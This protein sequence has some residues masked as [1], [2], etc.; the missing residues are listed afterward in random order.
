MS[1]RVPP[2]ARIR[3]SRSLPRLL[4]LP[5]FGL[6][7]GAAMMAGGLL[8]VPGITGLV[9]AGLGATVSLMSLAGAVVLLSVRLE[10]EEAAVCLAW[11][12]GE[13]I[14]P[15][16]PGPVTRVRLRGETASRLRAAPTFLPW[17]LGAGRLRDEEDVE[18]VRLAPTAT[19]ILVPTERGRLAIAAADEDALLDA[20]SRAARAR[21]RLEELIRESS[22]DER[23]EASDGSSE[24]APEFMTG[25]ER[26]TFE[27]RLA[28]ELAEAAAA[29]A[30][31]TDALPSP[32]AAEREA[33]PP[34]VGVRRGRRLGLRRPA[35]ARRPA[36]SAGLLVLP[37]LGAGIVWGI[38]AAQDRMPQPATDL[39]R[40]TA[41]ALV[42]GGPATTVGAI[43]AR[44]WWPRL[45]AVVVAGGL[46]ATV[47]VGRALLG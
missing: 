15:L 42:L 2:I 24:V 9:V 6:L 43:M 19:A 29:A 28:A 27:R 14:Y 36:P 33:Q 37:L 31:R 20:L 13:R 47:F 32:E 34:H 40:L 12:G 35:W 4:A 1:N 41:L 7:L 22:P 17:Q 38:A 44:V 3:L 45:V 10:I 5:M 30:A 39:G 23:A 25:I 21:Q 46:A 26:A 8:L 16:S 18:V 11:L